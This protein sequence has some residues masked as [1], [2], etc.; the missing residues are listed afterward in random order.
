MVSALPTLPEFAGQLV[1]ACDPTALLYVPATHAPHEPPSG[2]EY[3]ALHLQPVASMH[4]VH[5]PPEKNG[6]LVHGPEPVALFH[7]ATSH[8]VQTPPSGPVKLALQ[9]QLV[10]AVL[11]L[12]EVEFAGHARQ[13]AVVVAAGV[14]EYVAAEQAV[15]A[16]E[17]VTFL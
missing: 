6:Q 15:H 14:A 16:A 8:A 1:H 5:V 2:P 4:G 17:P 12:G 7:L 3:P 13:V 11:V 10:S 9:V